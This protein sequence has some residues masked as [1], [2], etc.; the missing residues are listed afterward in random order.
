MNKEKSTET[1]LDDRKLKRAIYSAFNRIPVPDDSNLGPARD[2]GD[3]DDAEIRRRVGGK[4]WPVLLHELFDISEMELNFFHSVYYLFTP[5]AFHYYLPAFMLVSL[6][7]IR[8]GLVGEA[9][10]YSLTPSNVP[11]SFVD[12]WFTDFVARVTPPQKR[13][14]RL[15]ILYLNDICQQL[16]IGNVTDGETLRHFW[17]PEGFPRDTANDTA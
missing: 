3:P 4:T 14:V 11:G 13:A 5:F 10:I 2:S 16:K 8:A 9:L 6:D 15:F 17:F 7:P 1:T 12:H